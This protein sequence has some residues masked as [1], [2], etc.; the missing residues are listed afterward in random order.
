VATVDA[1]AELDA[2]TPAALD[3]R[4]ERLP[5]GHPSSP[6]YVDARGVPE[7]IR[8]L[9]DAENSRRTE[10]VASTIADARNS[11]LATDYQH[12]TDRLRKVWTA[13]RAAQHDE[14][15]QDFYAKADA[16]PC[17]GKAILAGGLPGSGKTTVLSTVAGIDGFDYLTINPD[18]I[19]E[20]MARRGMVPEVGSLA[21]ME[22]SELVHEESSHIAKQL[23]LRAY[24]DGKNVI[25]DITMSSVVS[26]RQ[27]VSELRSAGYSHVEGVFVDIP[28]EVSIRRAE[29]RHREGH[30]EYRQGRGLGG[31]YVSPDLIGSQSDPESGSKNRATFE[32]IKASLDRWRVYD[33]SVDGRDAVLVEDSKGQD[34]QV[35]EDPA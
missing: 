21:P 29:A 33:N 17:D 23:A 25:W 30:E 12:T 13:D 24:A 35:R 32:Q 18:E 10:R 31:R 28:V 11:H 6:Q 19:K 26:T 2:P 3:Q 34:R 16:V 22:A 27:R 8:P 4:L 9:T 7:R 1:R 5:E 15:I 14:I 20:S